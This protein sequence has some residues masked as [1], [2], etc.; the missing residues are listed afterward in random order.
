MPS[1]RILLAG[2]MHCGHFAGLTPPGWWYRSR[3]ERSET[4]KLQSTLWKWYEREINKQKPFHVAL[5]NGDLIDGRGERSGGT[6]L[7]VADREEQCAMS[8]GVIKL[9][10]SEKNIITY[11]T[12]YHTSNSGEDFE[13]YIASSI[14]ADS[15]GGHEWFE[16]NG[17]TF[18]AKH[19]VG[20]SQVPH[21]RHT[22]IARERLWNQLWAEVGGAPK[23]DVIVRSHVHYYDFCGSNDF[24]A[25]TLPALQGPGSKYGVRQCSGIIHFGFVIFTIDEEGEY[26]WRAHIIPMKDITPKAMKC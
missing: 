20:S 1:K 13:N 5:W 15:I 14:K 6:E 21:G 23:A 3:G 2:D 8:I 25:M 12:P 17:I 24:L 19:K 18:D 9:A 4:Y 10:E 7:V 22:A 26:S 11:G 16:V